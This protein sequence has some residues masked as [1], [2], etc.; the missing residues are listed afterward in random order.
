MLPILEFLPARK[1]EFKLQSGIKHRQLFGLLNSIV[2][3]WP[4]KMLFISQI[5]L[6]S[7]NQPTLDWLLWYFCN[8]SWH[9]ARYWWKYIWGYHGGSPTTV[10]AWQPC[11][12][13]EPSPS[14]PILVYTRGFVVFSVYCLIIVC[15]IFLCTICT[16]STLIPLVGC[17]DL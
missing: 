2:A 5:V 14:L 6:I 13:L 16:F 4:T 1:Q 12:L 8:Q 17:F 9:D 10:Q 3:V 11:P 7:L 15:L